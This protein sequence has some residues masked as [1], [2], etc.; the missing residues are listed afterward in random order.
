MKKERG[1][2]EMRPK[3][4]A[5]ESIIEQVE[6][7]GIKP[8]EKLG[9]HFL[10]NQNAIDLLANVVTLGNIVI[11][12]GAGIGQLTE[13]LAHKATRVIA[14]EIDRRY[15]PILNEVT[16]TN[17]NATIIYGDALATE[18]DTFFPERKKDAYN[19]TGVQIV[20]SLPYHITEPFLHKIIGMPFESITLVVGQRL[21][22]SIQA[23]E[24]SPEFGQLS[25]LTQTFFNTD[26]LLALSKDEFFPR[27]RTESAIVRLVPK[28]EVEFRTNKKA[29]LLKRLFM[30]AKKS[31]LVK[32]CLKKELIDFS[33]A[34]QIGTLSKKE[35]NRRT[36]AFSKKQLR[37]VTMG[38]NAGG[39]NTEGST[40]PER[41]GILTQNQAKEIIA[42][43]NI[44][45]DILDKPF[46][47]LNNDD[48]RVLSRALGLI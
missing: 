10:I 28:E 12:I 36:R 29:H 48:L 37:E 17:P 34:S 13:A 44:P 26:V 3:A 38:Y 39:F 7:S 27:P 47:Q 46:Q 20:A 23:S 41:K 15:E 4:Q 30:T 31:P 8:N 42:R 21:A 40:K 45:Q 11:E 16:K 22:R 5:Q 9:Q 6:K 43:M 19:Q 2:T 32:N 24:S 1:A 14:I 25:L 18:F 35:H 33:Q